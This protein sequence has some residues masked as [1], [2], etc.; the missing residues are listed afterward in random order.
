MKEMCAMRSRLHQIVVP[1]ILL[2]AV[3]SAAGCGG[4]SNNSTTSTT[5]NTSTTTTTS[6]AATTTTGTSATTTSP[7]SAASAALGA[8]ASAGNCKS[9]ASLGQAYSAALS[10]S[11]T[12]DISKEATLLQQFAQKVPAAIKPDFEIFANDLT[13]VAAALG[14]YKPG[15]T[16]SPSA[17]AKLAS[18]ATSINTT[19]LQAAGKQIQA[20]ALANCKP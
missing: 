14:S 3:V 1:V 17:L 8:L 19:Q 7:S 12:V 16:P 15:T 10:G 9:L 11:G 13:K 18:L 20:W 5:S 2:A 4:S 6:T